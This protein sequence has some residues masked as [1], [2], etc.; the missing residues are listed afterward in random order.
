MEIKKAIRKILFESMKDS[1]YIE[2]LYDRFLR[3]KLLVVGYEIPGSIG[4][5]EEVGTYILPEN[6]KSQIIENAKIVEN[7]TFPK[8]KSYG[9]QLASINIDKTKVNYY[10]EELKE[11]SKKPIL[12]F[13]DRETESNGN[14]VYA[15]VRENT[16]KT[17]YFAKNYIQQ[18]P[19]KLRVDAILKNM[20]IVKTNK[21]R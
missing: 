11:L 16:L 20:D 4:Q 13:V 21:M 19:E 14:L 15:I 5:Y 6:I 2:R 9:V 8:A 3:E 7:A 18:T 17:I 1:H 12:V 10:S